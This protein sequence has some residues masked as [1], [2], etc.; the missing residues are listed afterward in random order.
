MSINVV[1][2]TILNLDCLADGVKRN[3]L[4]FGARFDTNYSETLKSLGLLSQALFL[5]CKGPVKFRRS[6]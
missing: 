3:Q 4:P 5:P 6:P 1:R 2:R